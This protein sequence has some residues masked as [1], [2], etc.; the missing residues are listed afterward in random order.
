MT[1][2]ICRLCHWFLPFAA[3]LSISRCA[4]TPLV[5]DP[6]TGAER[7]GLCSIMREGHHACGPK[8]DLFKPFVKGAA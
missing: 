2:P 5:V 1:A 6:V 4:V 8:G 3:D 7:H